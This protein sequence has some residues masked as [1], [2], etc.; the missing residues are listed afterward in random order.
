MRIFKTIMLILGCFLSQFLWSQPLSNNPVNIE[1]DDPALQE[2]ERLLVESYMNHYCFSTDSSLLNAFGYKENELPTFTAEVVGARM[3]ILDSN[4]PFQLVYNQ[5]VQKF[6]DLYA[7]RRKDVTSKVLGMSQ[8]YFPMIE[9]HLIRY[10]I[11]IELKYLAIVES[12]LNTSAISKVG[13]GGMWQFMPN[14]GRIYGLDITSYIDE[15]FDPYK[16]TD[17]ACKYLKHLYGIFGNWELVL[18]AYNSGPTNVNKAIRRAGGSRDFWTIKPYLPKETQGYVPAFIA[19]NYIMNHVNEYNVYPKKP[20]LSCYQVDT[21][22]VRGALH[23]EALSKIVDVPIKDIA[24]LNG[25]YKLHEIPENGEKHFIM[26]PLN[27]IGA[28]LANENLIYAQSSLLIKK[29]QSAPEVIAAG[30]PA[31][32]KAAEKTIWEE[33][34]KNH[35]VKRGE[36]IASV[37]KKYNVTAKEIKDWNRLRSNNLKSGQIIKIKTKVKKATTSN[38][39]SEPVVPN[40]NAPKN[41]TTPKNNAAPTAKPKTY[42]VKSGDTLYKIASKN[43]LTLE[44]LKKLNPKVS[45][46][47]KVGQKIIVSK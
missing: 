25:C 43:N 34:W 23:F 16:S 11:P 35:K 20:F 30:D 41:N 8:L 10:N 12:A 37:A 14:T 4:T 44:E 29:N 9:E 26:L 21:V 7:L 28:F 15:R 22:A 6:I 1:K 33:Q 42:T 2:I 39:E 31:Q 32:N 24:S 17:A 27:K 13:A 38:V 40:N 5:S 19:V 46:N 47:L 45:S 18:A 3:K 36:N